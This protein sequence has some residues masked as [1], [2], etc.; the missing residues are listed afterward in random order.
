MKAEIDKVIKH[1]NGKCSV[2]FAFTIVGLG[3][4]QVSATIES[5]PVFESMVDA[6]IAGGRALEIFNET[7][8]FPNMS[9]YF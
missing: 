3:N 1:T 6:Y 9:E 2:K 7:G 8:K 4:K 5:S